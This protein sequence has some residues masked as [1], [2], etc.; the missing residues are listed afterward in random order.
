MV[1]LLLL[2]GGGLPTLRAIAAPALT[3]NDAKV[4]D[5]L[6]S[7]NKIPEDQLNEKTAPAAGYLDD[8]S[9]LDGP[10]YASLKRVMGRADVRG[11]INPSLKGV[12]AGLLSNRFDCFK[13]AGN[14]WLAALR[15]PNPDTRAKARIRLVEFIQ[16]AHIPALIN[17]L[18][19]PGPN[20]LAF[21]ILEEVTGQHL[22][23]SVKAWQVWWKKTHG[24]VDVVGHL[25]NDTRKTIVQAHLAPIIQA[26]FWY[27]PDGVKEARVPL[28]KRSAEEQALIG[29]WDDW[30]AVDVKRFVED[31]SEIK[32]LM[33]RLIHQPD[34][35]VTRFLEKLSPDPA[36][37]DYASVLL[38]WRKD[39]S[40]LAV[41][42]KAYNDNASIGR[43][44]A[45][46]SLGDKT[47]LTDLLKAV[48][49]HRQ[50][51]S[52]GLM[53]DPLQPMEVFLR[54]VGIVPA[55]QAFE[56]LAHQ[57]FGL[58]TANT[59]AEKK[60]AFRK[61]EK[62]LHANF[63]SLQFDAAHGYFVLNNSR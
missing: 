44:L 27:L 49:E 50:P 12:L 32:P 47:A 58:K 52:Y 2:V 3:G 36:Y 43:A 14:L 59:R 25:M 20:V 62:W 38:A 15:S 11:P 54:T 19:V 34:P 29:Q 22:D 56:L 21:E 7:L 48:E 42:Q 55:E 33:D 17:L 57:V 61:A 35:R 5:L 9:D 16:P 31:F 63:N 28:A 6:Q 8:L 45:R 46:G 37:G 60:K 4:Y 13:L 41:I 23:P 18:K 10:D 39:Q 24:K 26:R 40:G 30:V 53:T 51:L 1:F